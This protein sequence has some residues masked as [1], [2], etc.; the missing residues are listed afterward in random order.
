MSTF[1]KPCAFFVVVFVCVSEEEVN[2]PGKILSLLFMG[3]FPRFFG[4][5]CFSAV[6]FLRRMLHMVSRF[7]VCVITPGRACE[8]VRSKSVV[9]VT[10]RKKKFLDLKGAGKKHSTRGIIEGHETQIRR[11]AAQHVTCWGYVMELVCT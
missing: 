9:R 7:M 11:L 2:T 5:F 4:F 10:M 1:A 8:C 6:S 3:I